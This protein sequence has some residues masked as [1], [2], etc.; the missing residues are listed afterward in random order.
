[1]TTGTAPRIEELVR[2]AELSAQSGRPDE[3]ALAWE[4]VLALAPAHPRALFRLGER[5]LRRGDLPGA[6]DFLRRAAQSAPNEPGI[7]LNLALVER[8]RG[9]VEAELAAIDRALA[10]EESLLPA[11]LMKGALL[12]RMGKIKQAARVYKSAVAVAPEQG[13]PNDIAAALVHARQVVRQQADELEEFLRRRLEPLRVLHSWTP[14]DRFEEALGIAVGKKRVYT[15][16][17]AYLLFPQLPAIA[18]YDEA[19]FPWLKNLDARAPQLRD[20]LVGLLEEEAGEFEPY[21]QRPDNVP[22]Q[23]WGELNRSTRWGAYFLWKDGEPVESHLKRCPVAAETLEASPMAKMPGYAP[24]AFFSS[25]DPRTH[26]P[27]HTGS[28][29]VRLIVHLP[30][31]VPGQC[32]FRV[33]NQTREW[34]FGKSW[35]FDDSIEHEAFND[36]DRQRVILIFDIWNPY[37]SEAEREL[38][39]AMQTGLAEYYE[40]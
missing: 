39:C 16:K 19:Q 40:S 10:I 15:Q 26:I 31:I 1:M 12:E 5:A 9:D 25:L 14:L 30:L 24:T 17:P 13:L 32:R 18:F 3:A 4:R 29:N 38:V 22:V 20:E 27:P 28:T 7:Q 35:V 33:A 21:V 11:L 2:A 36:S 8:A 6:R 37:L 34:E 23:Q